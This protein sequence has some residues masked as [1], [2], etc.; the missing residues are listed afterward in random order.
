M[1]SLVTVDQFCPLYI[2]P[3]LKL[4]LLFQKWHI[5]HWRVI[6]SSE[7]QLLSFAVLMNIHVVSNL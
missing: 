3:K 6:R 1:I 2:T 4:D 5:V 7:G